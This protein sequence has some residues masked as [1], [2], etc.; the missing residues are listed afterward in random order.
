MQRRI[1]P[2]IVQ[3]RDL[4]A[5]TVDAS[6]E[7]AAKAMA[8]ANVAAIVVMDDE[9][10]LIGILTERDLT[11]RVV[12]ENKLPGNSRVGDIMTANPD[13]L[14]PGDRASDA[15]ELMLTR[16]YRHLPVLDEN[17]KCVAMVSIRDLY[18]AVK[19]GLEENIRE[20]EAFVFGD[21]YSA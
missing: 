2:D 14:A 10:K 20:T 21:R 7:E 13:T 4:T 16:R 15:L 12:A 19:E 8:A 3:P 5:T 1:I 17:G 9:A 6:A 11:R 18:E